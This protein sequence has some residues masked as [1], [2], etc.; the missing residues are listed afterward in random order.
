MHGDLFPKADIDGRGY[1][2]GVS[3]MV[4]RQREGLGEIGDN[5]A[6]WKF[7][8]VAPRVIDNPLSCQTFFPAS[9]VHACTPGPGFLA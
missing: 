8:H 2:D 9:L 5:L 7:R 1:A 3:Q 4:T 6:R